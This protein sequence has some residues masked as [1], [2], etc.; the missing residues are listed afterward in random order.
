MRSRSPGIGHR[1]GWR[2]SSLHRRGRHQEECD[3][4]HR[5]TL[6]NPALQHPD[7][8][9]HVIVAGVSVAPQCRP[10][11]RKSLGRRQLRFEARGTCR[12]LFRG[13]LLNAQELSTQHKFGT[14]SRQSSLRIWHLIIALQPGQPATWKKSDTLAC[15]ATNSSPRGRTS[16]TL[17]FIDQEREKNISC[18]DPTGCSSE[19]RAHTSVSTARASHLLRALALPTMRAGIRTL[20]LRKETRKSLLRSWINF[21]WRCS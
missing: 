8:G 5:A 15:S 6:F 7:S 2:A 13:H 19:Q 18:L 12:S 3:F 20:A 11:R 17:V 16:R 4:P 21:E 10:L 1:L 14:V 9:V